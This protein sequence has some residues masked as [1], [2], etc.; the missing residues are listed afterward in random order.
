MFL[1]SRRFVERLTLFCLDCEFAL[2]VLSFWAMAW[3]PGQRSVFRKQAVEY[4]GVREKLGL[5]FDLAPTSPTSLRQP[6]RIVANSYSSSVSLQILSRR[7]SDEEGAKPA[8]Q[9]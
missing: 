7:G 6:S 8:P 2:D 3:R 9:Q 4:L 1:S 5:K